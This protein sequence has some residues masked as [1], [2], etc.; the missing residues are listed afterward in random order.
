ML[1]TRLDVENKGFR[2]ETSVDGEGYDYEW[3]CWDKFHRYYLPRGLFSADGNINRGNAMNKESRRLKLLQSEKDRV[4]R[5]ERAAT[6]P[7]LPTVR[8]EQGSSYDPRDA[9]E[10][11][12]M[13]V[14]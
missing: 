9:P 8:E 12:A 4:E 2:L 13:R 11:T 10:A 5:A 7:H 3:T 1:Y 6:V 14:E